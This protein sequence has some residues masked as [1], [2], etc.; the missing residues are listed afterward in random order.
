[1]TILCCLALSLC[2]CR[3]VIGGAI[4]AVSAGVKEK[5]DVELLVQGSLDAIFLKKV[6]PEYLELVGSSEKAEQ[7][8]IL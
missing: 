1:M 7:R 2:G 6:T 4:G 8:V 3:A 5:K